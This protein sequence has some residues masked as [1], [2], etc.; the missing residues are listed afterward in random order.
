MSMILSVLFSRDQRPAEPVDG[1]TMNMD[2]DPGVAK[3]SKH[4]S[5]N[6]GRADPQQSRYFRGVF[7]GEGEGEGNTEPTARLSA[8]RGG[9]SPGDETDQKSSGN[10][11]ST[12]RAGYRGVVEG[13]RVRPAAAADHHNIDPPEPEYPDPDHP[14]PTDPTDP[15]RSDFPVARL[16]ASDPHMLSASR[17]TSA[18][19]VNEGQFPPLEGRG[20]SAGNFERESSLAGMAGNGSWRTGVGE[21]EDEIS[22]GPEAGEVEEHEG[23]G[24]DLPDALAQADR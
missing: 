4:R 16:Y 8:V 9:L 7:T 3:K 6:G 23:A 19:S 17:A 13:E 22:G 20:S 24:D 14:D 11:T 12:N 10:N 21:A 1:T 18:G 15:A 2:P 5:N